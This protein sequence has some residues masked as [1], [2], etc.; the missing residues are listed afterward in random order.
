MSRKAGSLESERRGQ[1]TQK[2][3]RQSSRHDGAKAE[4]TGILGA[5]TLLTVSC[6]QAL[7]ALLPPLLLLSVPPCSHQATGIRGDGKQPCLP[8]RPHQQILGQQI[9]LRG[10]SGHEV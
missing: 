10:Y 1:R 5:G 8:D 6:H 4:R 2:G 3:F 9:W 7:L